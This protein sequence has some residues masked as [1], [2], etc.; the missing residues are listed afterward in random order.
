M[1]KGLT[2]TVQNEVKEQKVGFLSMLLGTLGASL[3]GNYLTGQG[4][5]RAGKGRRINRVGERIVRAGYSSHSSK[6]DF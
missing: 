3:L 5:N 4:V 6:M 2:K 1:L